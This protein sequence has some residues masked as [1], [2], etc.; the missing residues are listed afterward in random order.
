MTLIIQDGPSLGQFPWWSIIVGILGW[1]A[2]VIQTSGI[3]LPIE[4][5][6][7]VEC[8]LRLFLSLVG[9]IPE[10]RLLAIPLCSSSKFSTF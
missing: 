7:T 3:L 4:D 8:A 10:A 9:G 2:S 6:G 5:R 1:A